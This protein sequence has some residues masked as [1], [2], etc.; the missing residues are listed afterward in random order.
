M[1]TTDS[2]V[3]ASAEPIETAMKPAYPLVSN[4]PERYGA[5]SEAF[6]F[7][8]EQRLCGLIAKLKRIAIVVAV[9]LMIPIV[10]R[11][12]QFDHMQNAF[13]DVIKIIFCYVLVGSSGLMI[14]V[15]LYRQK[16][17]QLLA[18]LQDLAEFGEDFARFYMP[19]ARE[20]LRAINA[21]LT[22]HKQ[23]PSMPTSFELAKEFWPVLLLLVKKE[24]NLLRWGMAGVKALKSLSEFIN[25]KQNNQKTT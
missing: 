2:R 8:E 10:W 21:K 9:L 12:C 14:G 23:D 24:Q 17:L 13:L 5:L 25:S 22:R 20:E 16:I 18:E 3:D 19:Y 4:Q 11:L 15:F 1:P 7:I 6:L